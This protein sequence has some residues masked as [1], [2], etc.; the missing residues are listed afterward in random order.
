MLL[1][2]LRQ[3]M[4]VVLML[5][6]SM[7]VFSCKDDDEPAPVP[8]TPDPPVVELPDPTISAV[9][10]A[11]GATGT[12]VTITGTN[13]RSPASLHTVTFNGVAAVIK[14]GTST[15][16]TVEVPDKAGD[17]KIV[18]TVDGKTI[19]GPAFDYLESYRVSTFAGSSQGMSDGTGASAQF[20][21]PWDIAI[22]AN[23][24]MYVTD[25]DSHQIRKITPDGVVSTFAGSTAG[26]ADGT[27]T[28]AQF[29]GP[30]AITTD[31][32]GNVYV[33]EDVNHA[34][35]KITPDGV[36]TT[37]AG[38]GKDGDNDGPVEIA[39]F[40]KPSGIAVDADGNLYIGD[41]NNHRIRKIS[42]DGIVTTFAG[43]T[44]GYADGMGTAAQFNGPTGLKI[45]AEGNLYVADSYGHR[46]RKITAAGEVTTL[47]G[48]GSAGYADGAAA[49]A[50]FNEPWNVAVRA[51]GAVLVADYLNH[52]IRMIAPDGT[53]T[54]VAG[55][56]TAGN[57]DGIGAAASFN[58]PGS[59]A[60]DAAGNVY[61]TDNRNFRI[62]KLILE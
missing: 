58:E 5:C 36:V 2:L 17:G 12:V 45:D 1:S 9:N 23:G 10:P 13:F 60:I 38:N 15:Q 41:V 40:G 6:V 55:T 62:R 19:E 53:V 4:G 61:V 52:R 27:G 26:F 37:I 47:A 14:S 25:Y 31:A 22:D 20:Y 28:A 35:R 39:K 34:I 56:G 59:L 21:D 57:A 44:A 33:T 3:G 11:S 54:T 51:D 8:V 50:Q 42:P 30:T 16:L 46:I 29:N 24:V 18:L 43:S 49:D 7:L 48:N 32:A